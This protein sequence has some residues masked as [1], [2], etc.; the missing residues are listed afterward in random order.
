MLRAPDSVHGIRMLLVALGPLC[1]LALGSC[2][3]RLVFMFL[4]FEPSLNLENDSNV[5]NQFCFYVA[6]AATLLAFAATLGLARLGLPAG[7][8]AGI[9]WGWRAGE[10]RESRPYKS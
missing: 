3:L 2:S 7:E 8:P 4:V 6:F 1:G 10:Q 9:A 5:K